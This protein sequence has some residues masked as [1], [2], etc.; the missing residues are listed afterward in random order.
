MSSVPLGGG[1]PLCP[2]GVPL[3][4]AVLTP[5]WAQL[6][7]R[8]WQTRRVHVQPSSLWFLC[9]LPYLFMWN[10]VSRNFLHYMGPGRGYKQYKANVYNKDVFLN[11]GSCLLHPSFALPWRT[12]TALLGRQ[13]KGRGSCWSS[14]G[15]TQLEAWGLWRQSDL[16]LSQPLNPSL[17][18]P[19]ASS[20]AD[21]FPCRGNENQTGN[22]LLSS[23]C[24]RGG[25][26]GL[27]SAFMSC[28]HSL[29]AGGSAR[30]LSWEQGVKRAAWSCM[31]RGNRI[32]GARGGTFLCTHSQP[33]SRAL[34]CH[35]G[36]AVARPCPLSVCSP[37]SCF[38]FGLL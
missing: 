33:G 36:L 12:Q 24:H 10:S 23:S 14:L 21:S 7:P 6:A 8:R 2:P 25:R 16:H 19:G 34:C 13:S 37:G 1:L 30:P 28:C 31:A 15:Q 27:G 32:R 26:R 20:T 5:L 29:L 11:T 9:K 4:L 17:G 38:S 18:S 35:T 22:I 3:W